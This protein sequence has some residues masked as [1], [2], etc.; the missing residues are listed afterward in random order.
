MPE[1]L[2]V[3]PI[4]TAVT[5]LAVGEGVGMKLGAVGSAEG[6]ALVGRNVGLGVGLEG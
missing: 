5:W 3:T 4:C 6:L 2:A 1:T